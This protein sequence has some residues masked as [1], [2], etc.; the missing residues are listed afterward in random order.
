MNP[1][2]SLYTELLWRPLFNGLVWF[3]TIFPWQDLGL[4]IV[5]LT[6]SIRLLL[7]PLLLKG[8]KAQRELS[9]LQP[10][11]KKIQE[12]FKNNREAQSRALMELYAKHKV[13]PF[14]G[15]LPALIQLPMLIALFQ[16]FQKGVDPALFVYLYPFVSRP[17]TISSVGFGLFDLAKGNVYLGAAAALTQ[18]F[19]TTLTLP[20]SSPG[21]SPAGSEFSRALQW[22]M[23]YILP[24]F[25]L[26][27][28]YKLP[29][30]LTLYWTVLN[31]LG[32]LQEILIKKS[33]QG[34]GPKR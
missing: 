30:A 11:V 28:S 10:E 8:Q 1:L 34:P 31:I 25:I 23:R 20:A 14:S 13:N 21:N 22:Q 7:T 19:Q 26:F 9:S 2:V 24:L 15:C 33:A 3:Y 18:Y 32:I 27:W 29:S 6:I 17:E 4:A 5:A 12:Q 16:V